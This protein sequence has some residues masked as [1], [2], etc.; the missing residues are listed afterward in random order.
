[1]SAGGPTKRKGTEGPVSRSASSMASSGRPGSRGSAQAMEADDM[2]SGPGVFNKSGLIK[3][4]QWQQ[5]NKKIEEFDHFLH[6]HES[7]Y[8]GKILDAVGGKSVE[9]NSDLNALV[10]E[11][12]EKYEAVK[13]SVTRGT[14]AATEKK[15]SA[16]QMTPRDQAR[17]NEAR[18]ATSDVVDVYAAAQEKV[19]GFGVRKN[20]ITEMGVVLNRVAGITTKG[21]ISPSVL[22][23]I[24]GGGIMFGCSLVRK[25]SSTSEWKSVAEN[26]IRS[27]TADRSGLDTNECKNLDAFIEKIK[28][29]GV[30]SKPATLMQFTAEQQ[31][32]IAEDRS[33][34]AVDSGKNPGAAR[35]ERHRGSGFT[36]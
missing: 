1:M 16:G 7:E 8:R 10:D 32:A 30:L 11:M 23:I 4:T 5:V 26:V 36:N 15:K 9:V 25:M 18:G 20:N 35:A 12:D 14:A 17:K 31:Q 28:Q 19:A 24:K 3:G 6:E 34:M 33:R 27:A 2:L 29:P 21:D 22:N 13:S